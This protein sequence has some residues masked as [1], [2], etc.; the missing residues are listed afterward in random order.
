MRDVRSH[1]SAGCNRPGFAGTGRGKDVAFRAP[2]EGD[3][4]AVL[5]SYGSH[6]IQRLNAGIWDASFHTRTVRVS[7]E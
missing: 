2:L 6:F 1:V 7:S 4:G 5:S 3:D